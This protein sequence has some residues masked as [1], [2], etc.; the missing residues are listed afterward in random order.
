MIEGK[1][2]IVGK[3]GDSITMEEAQHAARNCILNVLAIIEEAIGD[4]NKVKRFVKNLTFVASDDEF[5]QQPQVANA[6]SKLLL[7]IFGDEIGRAAR[8]AV[9]VNCLPG[10]I[11][12]EIEMLIEI[13]K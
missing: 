8:S 9:G 2:S 5:Y 1:V 12:V 7:D 4:L 10:N 3:V 6:G 13:N 11:P